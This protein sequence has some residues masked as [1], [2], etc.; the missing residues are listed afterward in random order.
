MSSTTSSPL[1][2]QA[3]SF[4]S[5]HIPGSPILLAN[6]HDTTSARLIASLPSCKAIATASF[7]L[8][9]AN[10]TTDENLTLET[11]VRAVRD[12]AAAVQETGKPL[13]VDLQAGYGERL[14]EAVRAMIEMGVVG[15]N[16]EDAVEEQ[17]RA[18]LMEE[19]EAVSRV[20]RA[21]AEAEKAGVPDFV[22]NARSD[23][24]LRGGTL[25]EAIRRGKL[26]LEAGATC[27]YILGGGPGGLSRE[28]VKTAVEALDGK[29]NVGLRLPGPGVPETALTS[30][31]L[32]ELG[33]ARVS[34]GPQV[35]LKAVEAMRGAAE[36][37]LR[38]L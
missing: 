38:K 28:Q 3:Q 34:V 21:V 35:Y 9:L 23:S 19:C 24:F 7:S 27:V 29:V 25:D 32:A 13:S 30:K 37:V 14:E 1:N 12:I 20:K 17:G 2:A 18:I 15:I 8:A 4:K 26:Y 5:F 36:M 31:D 6:V 11:Q 10:G 22:V 33:V 16:I